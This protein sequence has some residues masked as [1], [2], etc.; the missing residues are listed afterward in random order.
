MRVGE[1]DFKS[2]NTMHP[3]RDIPVAERIIHEDFNSTTFTNELALLKLADS[4]EL[5]PHI[6]QCVSHPIKITPTAMVH[7]YLVG[8][9]ILTFV[10]FRNNIG[11]GSALARYGAIFVTVFCSSSFRPAYL[12]SLY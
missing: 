2:I 12:A 8:V 1:H 6:T 9:P 7:C 10:L 3:R 5:A 4:V 11:M